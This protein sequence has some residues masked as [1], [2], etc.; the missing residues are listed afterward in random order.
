MKRFAL[1]LIAAAMVLVA[2]LAFA[3]YGSSGDKPS[4]A[5][6]AFAKL[7]SLAGTWDTTAPEGGPATITYEVVSNGTAVME[8]ISHKAEANMITMYSVD[9]DHIMLTHYCSMGNQPRMRA[10]CPSGDI[11]ELKFSFLDGSNMTKK[12][13]HMH[14]LDMKFVDDSHVVET[15]SLYDKGKV[16]NDHTFNLTKKS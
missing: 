6:T 4:N 12:D 10:S 5:A 9:G 14:A 11:K 1:L 3:G 13:M 8:T 2:S 16:Q 15:W 7:K